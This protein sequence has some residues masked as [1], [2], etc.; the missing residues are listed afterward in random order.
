MFCDDNSFLFVKE[1][2][3]L[4][5]NYEL[6]V[7]RNLKYLFELISS[8]ESLVSKKYYLSDFFSRIAISEKEYEKYLDGDIYEYNGKYYYVILISKIVPASFMINIP[9]ENISI[10]QDKINSILADNP[11]FVFKLI[12]KEYNKSKHNNRILIKKDELQN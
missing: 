8:G 3:T 4:E 11:E 12:E 1:K 9:L 10:I 2:S 6:S 7:F 5:F